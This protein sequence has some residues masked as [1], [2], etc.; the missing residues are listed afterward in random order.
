MDAPASC[1]L[2]G[3]SWEAFNAEVVAGRLLAEATFL[4]A[5]LRGGG[6]DLDRRLSS[7]HWSAR[8]Y[9][10]HV[11]DVLIAVRDRM[12]TA[13]II[14]HP[15]GQPIYREE[16]VALGLYAREDAGELGNAILVAATALARTV[17]ALAATASS[18]SMRYGSV[19]PF[20]F[21][22]DLGW[23][24]QQ[25]LHELAHHRGDIAAALAS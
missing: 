11:R 22:A 10:G 14:D 21:D 6:D 24:A 18:R 17:E 20:D 23:V 1:E 9:A 12:V 15:T 13:S 4:N 2:C 25:G 7:E 19:P 8:E 3:F 5:E 16:R